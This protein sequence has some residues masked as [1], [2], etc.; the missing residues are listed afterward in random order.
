MNRRLYGKIELDVR[1]PDE[2][3]SV[4]VFFNNEEVYSA[5]KTNFEWLFSTN[6]Y[7]SGEVEIEV[8]AY[9]SGEELATGVKNVEFLTKQEF[10]KILGMIFG[11]GGGLVVLAGVIFFY[12]KKKRQ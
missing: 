12:M 5:E 10:N 2:A 6:D 8:K 3:D 9:V 1:A 4:K 11:I 7:S